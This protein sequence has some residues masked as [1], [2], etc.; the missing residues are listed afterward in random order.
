MSGWGGAPWG[1]SP[2]GTGG[3]ALT[4]LS[5]LAVRENVVRI[6]FD[7]PVYMS[8]LLDPHDA[9]NPEYF[10]VVADSSTTGLDGLPARPVAP[11]HV[12]ASGGAGAVLDLVI[13]RPLSPYPAVY[14]VAAHNLLT[15]GG[16]PQDLA[17]SSATFFGVQQGKSHVGPRPLGRDFANP[18]GLDA[19]IRAGAAP[20]PAQL[21]AFAVDATGDYGVDA[22]VA[23][24]KK[25]LY[26]RLLT[27]RGSFAHA[28]GYGVSV[29][30]QVKRLATPAARSRLRS[31]AEEQAKQEPEVLGAR[32]TLE[33]LPG[34][35]NGWLLT[36]RVR[37][38]AGLETLPFPL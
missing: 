8:E 32:A 2:W 29:V 16:A 28:P 22:G 23:S 9:A 37:T 5:A 30:D 33:R 26:R 4:L 38:R 12:V 1:L 10:T 31:E 18:S 34:A 36:L 3:T 17:R 14:L 27:K 25:R 6:S 35:A 15:A 13:D 21:G 11:A 24:L 7:Q 20:D 19:M